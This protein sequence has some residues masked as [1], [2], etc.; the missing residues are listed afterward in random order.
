MS[1]VKLPVITPR[2]TSWTY[3]ANTATFI[4]PTSGTMQTVARPGGRW[5]VQ[6]TYPPLT[7]ANRRKMK[8]FLA[9]LDGQSNRFYLSDHSYSISG[10]VGATEMVTNGEFTSGV[11][12]WTST[13]AANVAISATGGG[14]RLKRVTTTNA[15]VYPAVLTTVNGQAYSVAAVYSSVKILGASETVDIRA[16]TSA[17]GTSLL[18]SGSAVTSGRLVGTFT[19][20]GTSTYVGF[21]LAGTGSAGSIWDLHSFSVAKCFLVSG[22]SQT[23]SVLKVDG[24]AASQTGLLLSGDFIEVPGSGLHM[25]TADVDSDSSNV[26]YIAIK[27]ALRAS[28]ADNAAVVLHKPSMKA[29]LTGNSAGWSNAPSSLSDFGFEAQEIIE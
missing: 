15:S 9:G 25:V 7:G 14:G 29:I 28:P 8:A 3:N 27:P 18:Q 24:A 16:G 23:G 11:T 17:G 13:N 4:S 20:S 6:L 21:G 5:S 1:V 2:Q 10:S 26:A 12:G 19:A 22:A